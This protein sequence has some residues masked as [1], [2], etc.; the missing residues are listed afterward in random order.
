MKTHS[1]GAHLFHADGRKDGETDMIKVAVSFFF[2]QF[3]KWT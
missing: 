3:C 1:L 2:S